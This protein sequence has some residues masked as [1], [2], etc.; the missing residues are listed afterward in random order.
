M[1]DDTYELN[2]S[3]WE[4]LV[5]KIAEDRVALVVGDSLLKVGEVT[6]TEY[7]R[8]SILDH[9]KEKSQEVFDILS[10]HRS[11]STSLTDF[12][13]RC[14]SLFIDCKGLDTTCSFI[15]KVVD[16]IEDS[17]FDTSKLEN[18]LSIGHFKV[19]LSTSVSTRFRH[20]VENMANE[21]KQDFFYGEIQKG[22]L[23]INYV[24]KTIGEEKKW[25]GSQNQVL[26]VNLM[27]QDSRTNSLRNLLTSEEDMIHFVHSWI[28]ATHT[29]TE[30]KEYLEE[31]YMLMLGCDVPNWAFRFIWYLIKN[32]SSKYKHNEN[33][34]LC[35]RPNVTDT[36]RKFVHKFKAEI[37]NVK[38]TDKFIEDLK[39]QWWIN[40]E[41]YENKEPVLPDK[42]ID[43]FVSY[44]SEDRGTIESQIIPLLES[45]HESDNISF[46][47]D[48]NNIR[49]SNYWKHEI[50]KGVKYSRVFLTL[51]T[52]T[53]KT[54]SSEARSR[55]L[56]DEWG[57]AIGCQEEINIHLEESD[58]MY[59][60]I[61][62]VTFDEKHI[63]DEF[64]CMDIQ[65]V[66]INDMDRLRDQIL[67]LVNENR[68]F[69]NYKEYIKLR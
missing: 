34:A 62:P 21:K 26:F 13:E 7:L 39:A 59:T 43:V 4:Q 1:R 17:Q 64:K 9:A 52:E 53:S 18:I 48:Q 40:S 42:H 12:L 45:L 3:D 58:D 36:E 15:K 49:P 38:Y 6:M 35:T 32:P 25:C 55:Y 20:V 28:S 41:F 51:Q 61:L 57:F 2:E 19:I 66:Q 69:D 56:L 44:A 30:F 5:Q 54:I 50:K 37:M 63:A 23:K 22:V 60:Y 68:R 27:G 14:D 8:N 16:K 65:F 31:C 33:Y 11:I 24:S 29:A 46:W 67:C 10:S 47:Y